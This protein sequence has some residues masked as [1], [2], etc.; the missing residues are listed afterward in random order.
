GQGAGVV[1]VVKSKSVGCRRA[2][3]PGELA[4]SARAC[5]TLRPAAHLRWRRCRLG[6]TQPMK[7]LSYSLGAR[8]AVVGAV[9]AL[10]LAAPARADE[11]AYLMYLKGS[12]GPPA[13]PMRVLWDAPA[14]A[15]AH[16][17]LH[18]APPYHPPLT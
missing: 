16:L 13:V 12:E 2:G 3:F 10:A 15:T 14:P 1:G 4:A 18:L 9:A 17:T 7:H 6:S 5:G 11:T 8:A